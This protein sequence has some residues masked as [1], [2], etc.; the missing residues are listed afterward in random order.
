[1]APESNVDGGGTGVGRPRIGSG[2]GRLPTAT[3]ASWFISRRSCSTMF[4]SV[5]T[6][7][8]TPKSKSVIRPF[9]MVTLSNPSLRTPAPRPLPSSGVAVQVDGDVVRADHQAVPDALGDVVL[10]LD[11]LADGHAAEDLAEHR[12]RLRPPR[13]RWRAWRRRS[14]AWPGRAPGPG[15]C[16]CRPGRSSYVFGDSHG[17][18]PSFGAGRLS[19]HSKSAVASFE[20]KTNVAVV[21]TVTPSGPLSIEVSGGVVS[22]GGSRTV[23]SW[24]AGV[25]STLPLR[26]MARTA[27]LW[28]P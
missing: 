19:L 2:C 27:R 5:P 22:R 23:H 6:L 17:A 13:C 18:H 28:S 15:R 20:E 10:D 4:F 3:P 25:A 16:A 11:A 9:L 7:S 21:W 26:S 12:R 8:A 24:I 1:M 14:A